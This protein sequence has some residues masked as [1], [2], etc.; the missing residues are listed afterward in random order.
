MI[1]LLIVEF[2]II[3]ICGIIIVYNSINLNKI[4]LA[5]KDI[6][7]NMILKKHKHK[8]FNYLKEA[9]DYL[10][11]HKS[12]KSEK[13]NK[14]KS[15]FKTNDDLIVRS[16]FLLLED[17]EEDEILNYDIKI[18][19]GLCEPDSLID[20]LKYISNSNFINTLPEES[21]D[22]YYEEDYN[23]DDNYEK[24]NYENNIRD[25]MM[26]AKS[27]LNKDCKADLTNITNEL[28]NI[29]DYLDDYI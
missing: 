12:L 6:F 8:F 25:S 5:V 10:K 24:S 15:K 3:F 20:I 21:K 29:N 7:M 18:L 27:K 22:D 4:K 1:I 26:I 23:N 28:N 11:I 2:F 13:Y 9:S 14:I 16:L 17:C 19:V